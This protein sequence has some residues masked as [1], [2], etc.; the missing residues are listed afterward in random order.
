MAENE[1]ISPLTNRY[2]TNEMRRIFSDNFKYRTWRQLW[3]DLAVAEKELGL[4]ITTEQ[5]SEMTT[6]MYDAIDYDKVRRYENELHHDV[7]AHLREFC[8]KCPTAEP[9]IHLGATSCYITDNTDILLMNSALSVIKHRISILMFELYNFCN[10]F[11]G[12]V[13]MA[14]THLQPAQPT[15]VGKRGCMWLQDIDM[16]RD[17]INSIELKMLGCNGATGTQASFLELFDGDDYKVMRLNAILAKRIMGNEDAYMLISGQ[18]YTRKIDAIVL[19]ALSGIAQ[20]VHKMCSDI[21]LLQGMH[22]ICEPFGNKQVGSSAMAYKQNPIK[23]ENI[24]SLARH[25]ISITMTSKMNVCTQWLER[26]LDDSANRRIII[27]EAFILTDHILNEC[28]KI[29]NGLVVN[30]GIINRHIKDNIPFIAMES[31][32][33]NATKVGISRQEAHSRIRDLSTTATRNVLAGRDNNLLELIKDDKVL[34]CIEIDVD[35]DKM[36]G[37]AQKQTERYLSQVKKKLHKEDYV[38]ESNRTVW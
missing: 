6:H 26:S 14:H 27:S 37:M 7:M 4:D 35:P 19:D 12:T 36:I 28:S 5:T 1:Y 15:T 16:D 8:D 32:I 33:M 24:C 3:C 2:G 18:T 34:G 31:I 22:E 9:I 13:T 30:D 21:R 20:S 29:I 11:K 17:I 10:K 38:N 23:C 25:I